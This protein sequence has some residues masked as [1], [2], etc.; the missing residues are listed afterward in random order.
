MYY[1]PSTPSVHGPELFVRGLDVS[2]RKII[3]DIGGKKG[4]DNERLLK[5][6]G[7]IIDGFFAKSILNMFLA[8]INRDSYSRG[9]LVSG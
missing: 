6:K 3:V 2:E 1:Q 8:I 9:M 5:S 4:E 7:E